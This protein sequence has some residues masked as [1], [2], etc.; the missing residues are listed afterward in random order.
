MIHVILNPASG[1]AGK[2]EIAQ[3]IV[4][5]FEA[6]GG[7][8]RLHRV[9]TPADIRVVVHKI[10]EEDSAVQS[11][12]AGGGDGTISAV[13]SVLAG[14]PTPLGVLP[15]GT[16]NHFAKDLR[17]PL[18]LPKAVDT[19]V[20]GRVAAVDVGRVNEC[21]FLNNSSLGLYPDIV[22]RREQLRAQGHGKWTALVVA[23]LE[24][25]RDEDDVSVRLQAGGREMVSRTPF[26]FI[27]NNEYQVEGIHLGARDRLDAGRLFAYLAP[28]I[29]RRDLPKLLGWSL[30]GR[31]R[32]ERSLVV[33]SAEELWI[34]T[35]YARDI[36]VACDGEV[37]TLKTPLHYRV[38]PGALKV[39]TP[40]TAAA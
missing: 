37:A 25:W 16:L 40:Q 2:P 38:W 34:E 3:Q 1:T 23:T 20:H 17:I 26:V 36:K 29:H 31:V 24:V 11:V 15:L 39:L 32:Q 6:A 9:P 13:A 5:S 33:F 10:F 22:E 7:R 28:R 30:L 19:I 18:D 27:G 14:G 4:S 8:I 35:P 12:V 21:T